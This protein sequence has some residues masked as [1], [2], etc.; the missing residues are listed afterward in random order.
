MLKSVVAHV[1]FWLR[2]CALWHICIIRLIAPP[3]GHLTF[4][5]VKPIQ[6]PTQIHTVFSKILSRSAFK[7][8]ELQLLIKSNQP[9]SPS[10][11]SLVFLRW[12]AC[13]FCLWLISSISYWKCKL[14]NFPITPHIRPV[15]WSVG[16]LECWS[17][18]LSVCHKFLKRS[19]SYTYG[20]LF[21]YS[22]KIWFFLTLIFI[23]SKL[24]L[25][26]KSDQNC[27]L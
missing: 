14:S 12:I 20:A 5:K 4:L 16:W 9:F 6:F 18:G 17:V 7:L 21:L 24:S 3:S 8:I 1:R 10:A 2:S 26:L 15:G 23:V 27:D 22:I 13:S 25:N 19:E 11:V